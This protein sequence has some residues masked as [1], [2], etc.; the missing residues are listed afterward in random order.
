MV[1]TPTFQFIDIVLGEQRATI[2]APDSNLVRYTTFSPQLRRAIT[3]YTAAGGNILVSGAYVASDAWRG[4]AAS[5]EYRRFIENTLRV[6]W[7]SDRAAQDGRLNAA[8]MPKAYLRGNWQFCQQ[9][10]DSVY[11]V[12]SPDA[13]IPAR[14]DAY[15]VLQYSQNTNSAA[16]ICTANGYTSAVCGFPLETVADT[17]GRNELFRQLIALLAKRPISEKVQKAAL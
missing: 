6:Q 4:V 16:V 11:E 5:D 3:D 9:L 17:L 15:T 14:P 10:N 13:I 1:D 12:E 8:A 2:A 7:R